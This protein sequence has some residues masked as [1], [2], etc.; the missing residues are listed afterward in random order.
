[1]SRATTT[2]RTPSVPGRTT[3]ST[4]A[5]PSARTTSSFSSSGT[6]PR[7]S[8]ALTTRRSASCA[9][10]SADLPSTI[11]THEL[12]D[13]D[14]GV[15]HAVEDEPASLDLLDGRGKHD[16]A[17]RAFQLCGRL[18]D[19]QRLGRPGQHP[20]RVDGVQDHRA[21][22]V[23]GTVSQGEAGEVGARHAVVEDEPALGNA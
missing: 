4:K 18:R 10:R 17:E 19:E 9:V 7:T 12:G 22:R 6:T 1:M 16:V 21:R 20:A 14:P 5:V 15:G 2:R 3:V 11:E 23:P 8:Y 13:T